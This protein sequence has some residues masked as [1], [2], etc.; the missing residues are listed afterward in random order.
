[1]V[2]CSDDPCKNHPNT[3]CEESD[4]SNDKCSCTVGYKRNNDS[5]QGTI[6]NFLLGRKA[7][8]FQN[9]RNKMSL[10]C[11]QEMGNTIHY[12]TIKGTNVLRAN[13]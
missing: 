6:I 10:F 2:N 4:V 5:C 13:I 3:V 7:L 1:M 12:S 8:F 11:S 9:K